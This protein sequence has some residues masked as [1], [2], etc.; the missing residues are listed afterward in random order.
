MTEWLISL[1]E[2][3][4]PVSNLLV[5]LAIVGGRVEREK[6]VLMNGKVRK[7]VIGKNGCLRLDRGAGY[8]EAV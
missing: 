1:Y 7:D 4:S 6:G 2:T 5:L 3:S 8:K